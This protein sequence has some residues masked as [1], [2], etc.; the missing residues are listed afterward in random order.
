[1]TLYEFLVPVIAFAVIGAG[2]LLLRRNEARI[3]RQLGK[4]RHHPA[5]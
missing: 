3:D 1:M 4:T 2:Y 5:E